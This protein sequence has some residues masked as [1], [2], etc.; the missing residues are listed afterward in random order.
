[1]P[2]LSQAAIAKNAARYCSSGVCSPSHDDT[3]LD[4]I[5]DCLDGCPY[6]PLKSKPGICGCGISD[7]DR[8]FDKVPD[9]VDECPDDPNN[10]S[11][12]EC[13]CVGTGPALKP[14]GT[15]CNDTACPQSS[16]T[17]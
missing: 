15:P 6:D 4:T 5:E 17:C 3:D 16:A 10:T 14:A 12:G 9:C 11:V 7:V 8:D 13:G 2:G 1:L